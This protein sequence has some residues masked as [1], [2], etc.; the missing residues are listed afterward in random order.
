MQFKRWKVSPYAGHGPIAVRL[1]K[2][3]ESGYPRPD[4]AMTQLEGL[5]ARTKWVRPEVFHPHKVVA[6]TNGWGTGRGRAY[7][8]S[9]MINSQCGSLQISVVYC[10]AVNLG[11]QKFLS[12]CQ[13]C[14]DSISIWFKLGECFVMGMCFCMAL[15]C[16]LPQLHQA[17]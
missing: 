8:H 11:H 1:M 7:H 15:P 6:K 17:I 12:L 9:T 14:C 2:P 13:L 3:W 4:I 10:C 16:I 5:A